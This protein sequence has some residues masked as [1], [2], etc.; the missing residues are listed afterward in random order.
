[1]KKGGVFFRNVAATLFDDTANSLVLCIFY[2]LIPL[3][4]V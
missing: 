2:Y 3:F 1:M 4:W